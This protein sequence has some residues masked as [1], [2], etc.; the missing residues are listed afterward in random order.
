MLAL[1]RGARRTD[2]LR[3]YARACEILDAELGVRPGM[4]LERLAAD[5]R[6]ESSILD[7]H[8]PVAVGKVAHQRQQSKDSLQGRTGEIRRLREALQAAHAGAAGSW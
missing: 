3:V 6:S 2:A 5:V 4:E 1:Y 7:W 8:P